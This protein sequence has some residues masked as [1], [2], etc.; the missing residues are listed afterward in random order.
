MK[1]KGQGQTSGYKKY[2]NH[3][4]IQ[5]LYFT[6]SV[7]IFNFNISFTILQSWSNIKI[8]KHNQP[9]SSVF[10]ACTKSS[11]NNDMWYENSQQAT[12]VS[13]S[14]VKSLTYALRARPIGHCFSFTKIFSSSHVSVESQTSNDD[15]NIANDITQVGFT[16]IFF[17][18][19]VLLILSV[20]ENMHALR[21]QLT[22][23][24]S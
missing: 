18:F 4:G 5:I 24:S 16:L 20:I 9:W 8:N 14:L 22:W 10:R 2:F 21:A 3:G 23:H 6:I 12:M 7:L 1:W 17:C 15:L 13:S 11:F 19:F